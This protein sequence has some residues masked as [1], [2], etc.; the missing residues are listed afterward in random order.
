MITRYNI[1][2]HEAKDVF[3]L[4]EEN[5]H[6]ALEI[7]IQFFFFQLIANPQPRIDVHS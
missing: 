1:R 3:C 6:N 2:H 7:A 4:Y 5:K